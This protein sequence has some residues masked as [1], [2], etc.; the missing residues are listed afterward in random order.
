MYVLSGSGL[1][2]YLRISQ[3]N[4]DRDLRR[5]ILVERKRK[6]TWKARRENR[7]T[8]Q[9]RT[10]HISLLEMINKLGLSFLVTP[11]KRGGSH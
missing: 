5:C 9:D 1:P 4:P 7:V 8:G 6:L 3:L 10:G 2:G 11:A